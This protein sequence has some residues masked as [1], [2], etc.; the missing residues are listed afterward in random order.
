[1]DTG[2]YSPIHEEPV[3]IVPI[4]RGSRELHQH[5]RYKLTPL[6]EF[7]AGKRE[8]VLLNKKS[9]IQNIHLCK[10]CISDFE[11]S[12]NPI[13]ESRY[14][15]IIPAFQSG[16]CGFQRDSKSMTKRYQRNLIDELYSIPSD[17]FHKRQRVLDS[18]GGCLPNSRRQFQSGG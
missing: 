14:R 15:P 8:S 11:Q 12:R 6:Y 5:C 4:K 1:M 18:D 16:V 9:D 3:S 7:I 2:L 17:R 10:L 13:Q